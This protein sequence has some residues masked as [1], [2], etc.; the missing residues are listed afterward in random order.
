MFSFKNVFFYFLFLANTLVFAQPIIP[1][2][3]TN[4]IASD[5]CSSAPSICNLNG[6]CGN[7]SSTYTRS[8]IAWPEIKTVSFPIDNDS[9]VKFIASATTISFYVW[10]TSSQNGDG[11]QLLVFSTPTCGSGT[12]SV[13]FKKTPIPQSAT[14]YL[15]SVPG[16][17]IGNTYYLLID[18]WAGDVCD[19]VIGVDSNGGGLA[20][21]TAIT[22][23]NSQICLGDYVDLTCIGGSVNYDWTTSPNVADL[24]LTNTMTVR[25]TPTSIGLHT[26]NVTTTQINVSCPNPPGLATINVT[27]PGVTAPIVGDTSICVNE[28]TVLTNSSAGGI[29]SVN[30]SNASIYVDP[31]TNSCTLTG[32]MG[33][34]VEI[35][36]TNCNTIKRTIIINNLSKPKI[37]DL[38]DANNKFCLFK[39]TDTLKMTSNTGPSKG[40]WNYVSL[41]TGGEAT[42]ISSTDL[43]TGIQINKYGDYKFVFK[44]LVCNN[45]DS[46][47][48]KFRPGAYADLHAESILCNGST[49]LLKPTYVYPEYV[50][51][52]VWNTGETTQNI[53]V[54]DQNLYTL[55]VNTGCGAPYVAQTNVVLKVCDIEVVPNVITPNGDKINDEF[56]INTD[57]GIFKT[58][59]I[60]IT[61]RWGQLITQYSDPKIG[62]WDGKNKTGEIVDEGVYFFSL[63]AE[64]I[65]GKKISKQG[66]IHVI[67]E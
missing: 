33:G 19:Y 23:L 9:Y 55:T 64:T 35:S 46:I 62:A 28:T 47:L 59:D 41:T 56:I 31:I 13:F 52:T 37:Y 1:N 26:Y 61:N 6:Y 63:E 29:W 15:I 67:N 39:F 38:T 49:L 21:S 18:G 16:L 42:F 32:L 22:P 14:P 27:P 45:S 60:V 43:N 2:C 34:S 54:K 57:I 20:V 25:A 3:G 11:I 12:P 65:E 44:E 51:S 58:F 50:L 10:V 30:N 17:T 36:Y 4:P 66:F 53:T 40:L 24:N 5:E 7:T 8:D 48:V